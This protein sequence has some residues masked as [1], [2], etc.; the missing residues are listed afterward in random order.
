MAALKSHGRAGDRYCTAIVDIPDEDVR[1]A[2][3]TEIEKLPPCAW[4][5]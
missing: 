1:E 2:T 3:E 4:C 5:G